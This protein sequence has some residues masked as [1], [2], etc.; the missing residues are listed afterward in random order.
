MHPQASS[1]RH[2]VTSESEVTQKFPQFVSNSKVL[3][4]LC[5]SI[6]HIIIVHVSIMCVC[7][8]GCMRHSTHVGDNLRELF[9][10]FY[11]EAS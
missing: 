5:F 3:A 7:V 6:L 2:S 9:L 10:F 4:G 11:H 1:F 8:G